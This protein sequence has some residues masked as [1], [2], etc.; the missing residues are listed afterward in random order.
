MMGTRQ[1]IKYAAEIDVLYGR[2]IYFPNSTIPHRIKKQMSRRRRHEAKA[3]L[4]EITNAM[5]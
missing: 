2:K 4:K 3:G 1:K 5:S